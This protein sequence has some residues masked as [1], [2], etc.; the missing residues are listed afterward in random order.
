MAAGARRRCRRPLPCAALLL[1]SRLRLA[2][3]CWTKN[4]VLVCRSDADCEEN[5]K[6]HAGHTCTCHTER[7]ICECMKDEAREAALAAAS[8]GA[9]GDAA[10]G[11]VDRAFRMA[12]K[13]GDGQISRQEATAAL[14]PDVSAAEQADMFDAIDT[15]GNGYISREELRKELQSEA[16][17]EL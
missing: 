7:G 2:A 10:D 17:S 3:A 5:A 9:K 8:R 15:D 12:D 1:L 16:G 11:M 14:A 4:G 6:C 13:D